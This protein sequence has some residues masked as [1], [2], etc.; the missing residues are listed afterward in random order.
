M[1]V[2]KNQGVTR[3]YNYLNLSSSKQILFF[4]CP[5]F[6][7]RRFRQS[8]EPEREAEEDGRPV[9]Q[10]GLAEG[11]VPPDAE[12]AGGDPD[13][14]HVPAERFGDVVPRTGASQQFEII[15]IR[16]DLISISPSV[17]IRVTIA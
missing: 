4:S 10:P 6:I 3:S 17:L 16:K 14:E 1:G 7:L 11:G 5:V 12:H 15:I 8:P 9:G 13:E 2:I